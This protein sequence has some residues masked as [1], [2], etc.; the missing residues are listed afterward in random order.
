[1]KIFDNDQDA[2]RMTI[3]F[4][5]HTFLLSE[6]DDVTVSYIKFNMVKDGRY[7]QY[8][9]GKIAF[10]KLLNSLRQDFFIEKQ[11]YRLGGMPHVLNVWMYECYSKVDKDIVCRIDNHVNESPS[12]A[13]ST[14]TDPFNKEAPHE[15]S[16][17]DFDEQHHQQNK[18][19]HLLKV[20][21]EIDSSNKDVE[22]NETHC[23]DLKTLK[24]HP[25]DV[26]EKDSETEDKNVAFQHTIDN[27]IADFSSPVSAIQSE[28]LLQ[29][30]NLSDLILPTKNTKFLNELQVSCT[31][32]SSEIFQDVIDNIIAGMCTLITAV[33]IN[34]D[35]LLQKVNFPDPSL[36]TGNV[37]VSNELRESTNDSST[38]ASQKFIDNIIAV[39]FTPVVAMKM[40][41]VS[42]TE[43][44]NNECQIHDTRFPSVLPEA[45][46]VDDVYVPV[47]C[48]ENFHWVLAV[49][50]LKKRCIRVYDSIL[51]SQ[52]REPS[53]EIKKLSGML[54]TYLTYSEF[55][56][57]TE[58]TV[59]SSLETYTDKISKVAGDLNETP[60][61]VEY[62]EYIAQQFSG[63]LDCGVF[64]AA[65]AEFLSDQMQISSSNLDAE[66]LRK[67][68][69]SLL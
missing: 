53:N 6:I 67:R 63:S 34:S 26:L 29:K 32:I 16:L 38:D 19:N 55:L 20:C 47:N 66:Y 54:P 37:E 56:E 40:K 15:P 69:A 50:S 14:I 36:Q 21:V 5:I 2:L 41:S 35:N 43:I 58:R 8:P 61:D 12:G 46:L 28:E 30:E 33:A 17:M 24:E 18:T 23:D 1:M 13:S 51:S 10:N 11:L 59:W 44:N 39:I 25:K 42:P 45:E 62:V 68:Y 27:T 49:I 31:V 52:H 60:F 7:E 4:F 57:N 9:W 22:K 64:V 65:Y 3:L 48:D